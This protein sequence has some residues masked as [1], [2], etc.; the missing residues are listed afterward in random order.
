MK[1]KFTIRIQRTE[2]Y[3]YDVEVEAETVTD[4]IKNVEGR[5]DDDEFYN[6]FELPDDTDTHIYCAEESEVA[7]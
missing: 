3:S 4:A 5:Y 6:C 7:E 1:R 2:Y